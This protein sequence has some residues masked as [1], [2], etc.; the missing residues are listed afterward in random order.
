MQRGRAARNSVDNE[1]AVEGRKL[2]AMRFGESEQVGIR[3]L[4]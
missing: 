1:L 3:N 2:A 4:S